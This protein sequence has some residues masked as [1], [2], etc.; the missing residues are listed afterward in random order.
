MNETLIASQLSVRERS[1]Q[2][3]LCKASDN[4]EDPA[5]LKEANEILEKHV[6]GDFQGEFAKLCPK[7][8]GHGVIAPVK[9][10]V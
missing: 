6:T 10:R 1:D 2:G 9:K 3:D 7:C 4:E 5:T 8:C